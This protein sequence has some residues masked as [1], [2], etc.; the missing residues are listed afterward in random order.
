M[1]I[2]KNIKLQNDE[3]KELF[4]SL[5]NTDVTLKTNDGNNIKCHKSI[6]SKESKFFNS[7]FSN[8]YSEKNK[9][10]FDFDTNH[11][12]LFETIRYIY[13]GECKLKSFDDLFK[14]INISDMLCIKDL[15]AGLTELLNNKNLILNKKSKS[16][17]KSIG[18][19][20]IKSY[21]KQY[22]LKAIDI[23]VNT[24]Y[25]KYKYIYDKAKNIYWL[26]ED[27]Y[28][29]CNDSD[30]DDMD[31]DEI[32]N[33]TTSFSKLSKLKFNDDSD[34]DYLFDSDDNSDDSEDYDDDPEPK[35]L[36]DS[37][38]GAYHTYYPNIYDN[39]CDS[40]QFSKNGEMKPLTFLKY[41]KKKAFIIKF[42]FL[43]HSFLKDL[44][45]DDVD[46]IINM[47]LEKKIIKILEISKDVKDFSSGN[48]KL[49]DEKNGYS[50]TT[51][52]FK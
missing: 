39:L 33:E 51:F 45:K 26:V 28:V 1:Y 43:K 8:K 25:N 19:F 46:D 24:T 10:V 9:K 41:I 52:I 30:S 15:N 11:A 23:I 48:I 20:Y 2:F 40:K 7:L 34:S 3:N 29:N 14:M 17:K 35:F 4:S 5:K 42:L 49:D 22:R 18:C 16:Y 47:T 12:V 38:N 50:M 6:L 32:D 21:E 31:V 37:K 36:F 13:Y 44:I 27:T